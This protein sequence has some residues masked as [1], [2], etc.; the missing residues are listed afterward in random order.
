MISFTQRKGQR[1]EN[2]ARHFL[3]TQGLTFIEKNYA[4]RLGEIDLIMRDEDALVFIEVRSRRS[5][6]YGNS[7]ETVGPDKQKRIFRTAQH[8]LQKRNLYDQVDCRF[9]VVGF[10]NDSKIAWIKDA[11]QVQY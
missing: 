5:T 8:Y 7:F 1:A 4:C 10:D 3:E 6:D 9:D 11:F 2:K